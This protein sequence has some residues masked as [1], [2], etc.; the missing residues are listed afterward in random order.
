ML[1]EWGTAPEA[2]VRARRRFELFPKLQ[3][4]ER[5]GSW[6]WT[7]VT[8]FVAELDDFVAGIRAG[9]GGGATGR[10]GLRALQMAH[11]IY[12]SSREGRQV[13]F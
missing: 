10:D 4:Q 9:R 1:V 2:G 13:T 8:S 6:R 3:V 11:A 12:R 7:V 5:L